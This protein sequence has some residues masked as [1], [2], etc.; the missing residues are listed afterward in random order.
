MSLQIKPAP[1]RK[2]VHVNA[3]QER[4]FRV[5]TAGMSR[6]WRPDHHIAPTP[7]V[8]IVVEPRNGGRWYEKDKDGSECEWGK[9]LVWQPPGR[10]VL[11][12]QLNAEWRY[13]PDFVTEL[14]MRFIAESANRTRVELEH[15]DLEKFGDRAEA[16]RA[17]LDSLD[18]W[19]GALVAYV[20]ASAG[21]IP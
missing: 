14:E 11:A 6:W 20:A 2:T 16:V 10:L 17:S 8:D 13:D 18:G 9:V 5:F 7:F 15:R 1:V 12:W 4:A 3:P 19:N 21:E